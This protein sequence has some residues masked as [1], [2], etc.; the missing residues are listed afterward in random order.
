MEV[1]RLSFEVASKQGIVADAKRDGVVVRS[2]DIIFTIQNIR[3]VACVRMI[4]KTRARLC[5]C[6]VDSGARERGAGTALVKARIAYIEKTTVARVIDT[7]AFSPKL[8]VHLG[9]KPTRFFK[10]GTTHLQRGVDR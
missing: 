10:M 4:G 5:G 8:F 2:T 1:E 3:S 9:F 7:F 6:W